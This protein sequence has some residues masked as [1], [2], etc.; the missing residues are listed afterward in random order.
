VETAKLAQNAEEE[1]RRKRREK[2]NRLWRDAREEYDVRWRHLI[3]DTGDESEVRDADLKFE[4]IPWPIL[5]AYHS[6]F[7]A[8]GSS[9]RKRSA[10]SSIQVAFADDFSR[11]LVHA[12]IMHMVSTDDNQN[13]RHGIKHL[14]ILSDQQTVSFRKNLISQ[15]ESWSF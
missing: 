14:D 13:Q 11:N 3:G 8:S 12:S 1:R 6:Q 9:A 10:T 2:E 4:D 7:A 15:K 5:S